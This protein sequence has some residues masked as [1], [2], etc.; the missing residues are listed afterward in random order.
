MDNKN[1]CEIPQYII[2]ELARMLLPEIQKFYSNDEN[3]ICCDNLKSEQNN[4]EVK[5]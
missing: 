3:N 2:D 1:N 4:N 5:L